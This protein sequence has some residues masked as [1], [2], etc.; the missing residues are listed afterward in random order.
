MLIHMR[1]VL[2]DK[3]CYFLQFT[4]LSTRQNAQL[5][6]FDRGDNVAKGDNIA[7][8]L[9]MSENIQRYADKYPVSINLSVSQKVKLL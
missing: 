3:F 8:A 2:C 6:N 9:F 1:R 4:Y 7:C 5:R